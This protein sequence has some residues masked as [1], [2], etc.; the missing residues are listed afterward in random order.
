MPDAE[1]RLTQ[2]P[3]EL[4]GGMKQR[5]L[6]A[7]ALISH[8]RLLIADEPTTALDAGYRRRVLELFRTRISQGAGVLLIS[9]DLASVRHIADRVLVMQAGEIVEQGPTEQ[10]LATPTHSFTRRLLTAAPRPRMPS[11]ERRA[12]PAQGDPPRL[13]LRDVSLSYGSHQVLREISLRIHPGET[14]GLA[15]WSGQGKT[16]LLRVALG[17]VRA[18]QGTVLIDGVDRQ[19]APRLERRALRRRIALV[20]QDPLDFFP[21]GRSG[22]AILHDALRAAGVP[23]AARAPRTVALAAEVDLA[24]ELLTRPTSTL[25][26]GQ[27]QR[28]A[29]ARALAQD[30]A[31]LLL[32][33]PV[34]ALDLTVQARVLDVLAHLQHARNMAMLFVSH[35][36]AVLAQV[37]DRIVRLHEGSLTEH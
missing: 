4:S 15:G 26:G 14:V 29:I 23:L 5:A 18:D 37:S 1:H 27:R 28:L 34:S 22:Q 11:P 13:E 7:A 24:P 19:N 8:P 36:E 25:S 9:H 21:R 6:I 2:R 3:D 31:I 30:P 17:L 33:E 20:P 16:S 10:V 32:D 12:S 35:D